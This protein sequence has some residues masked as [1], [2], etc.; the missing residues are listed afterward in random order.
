M[1]RATGSRGANG[2]SSGSVTPLPSSTPHAATAGQVGDAEGH[3]AAAA[4]ATATANQTLAGVSSPAP[5]PASSSAG[6]ANPPTSIPGPALRSGS[7]STGQTATASTP[8]AG[9]SSGA[10][11]R[12]FTNSR[13]N[14]AIAGPS[15]VSS[16]S[17]RGRGQTAASALSTHTMH[18]AAA[19]S[20]FGFE[21]AASSSRSGGNG[22]FNFSQRGT[23]TSNDTSGGR[24]SAQRIPFTS[25]GA[26]GSPRPHVGG[27][28]GAA[29]STL[30]SSIP[31]FS[32]PG[33]PGA[34]IAASNSQHGF[35][36]AGQGSWALADPA[37]WSGESSAP[38]AVKAFEE[39]TI[40]S[41]RWRISDLRLLRDEV[42]SSALSDGER[43]ISAG[44]GK[45]EI[46]T[47][48][49]IFG[50]GKWKLELVRTSRG[51]GSSG[52]KEDEEADS[53][54]EG[55]SNTVL[56]VY[57]TAM[58]LDY[59]P[60][61]ISIA[62]T[63]FVGLAPAGRSP[64][65]KTSRDGGFV[66]RHH[67]A[68]TFARDDGE[69][70]ECH[71]LPSLTEL[72]EFPAVSR[73]NAMEL[74]LQ[75]STGPRV[76]QTPESGTIRTKNTSVFED[77][78]THSVPR[79]LVNGLE[80]LLDC[81]AT[82]DVILLVKERGLRLAPDADGERHVETDPFP[83]SSGTMPSGAGAVTRD[84][85]LWA[86]SSIL[87]ARGEFWSD[88][89]A[90]S[91]AEGVEHDLAEAYGGRRVR[92]LRLPDADF[93]S[94]Y[95]LLRWLYVN[96]VEFAD[97]FNQP[98]RG[99]SFGLLD[100]SHWVTE[101][102]DTAQ[103]LPDWDW[104]ECVRDEGEEHVNGAA[105]NG[106][107]QPQFPLHTPGGLMS[108]RASHG[109]VSSSTTAAAEG[110]QHVP[111]SPPTTLPRPRRPGEYDPR[112]SRPALA[113]LNQQSPSAPTLG[114]VLSQDPHPHPVTDLAPASAL[115]IYRL[116][117]RCAQDSLAEL[118]RAHVVASLD[119]QSA[120]PTFLATGLYAELHADV[121]R[122][123]LA[124]WTAVSHSEAFERSID[125]ICAGQWGDAASR[126]LREFMRA[127]T[128]YSPPARRSR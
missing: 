60:S 45:S 89:L 47:T 82:G 9:S 20:L 124:N 24:A 49:P 91:F 12:E 90:S 1:A 115:T 15:A 73:Q 113:A 103:S 109:S 74:T 120:F 21:Q 54:A 114:S 126:S 81:S 61:H 29:G 102:E 40:T 106:Q 53:S 79:A 11:R 105:A 8:V 67:A 7:T 38:A 78:H 4:S 116:A 118:A 30:W 6:S 121:K 97:D 2:A 18:P 37:G 128:P 111:A 28:L 10:S 95:A 122:Y 51:A 13:P 35:A 93:A 17:T 98:L 112:A 99:E 57:L 5:T 104:Q 48:Q 96:E 127:L 107:Q 36:G 62:A 50:D 108:S 66:W 65:I 71:E 117:H 92:V 52:S 75:I 56:S 125:E 32:S 23:P 83:S 85:V 14:S 68:H 42:E 31:T 26:Q 41:F 87:R 34:G 44:A 39:D 16:S 84:R 43:S 69:F 3:A 123:L 59:I 86:H 33:R 63:I 88:M 72:L 101:E 25:Q 119:P 100:D 64:S 55:R 110:P 77:K 94:A 22:L 27:M 19:G 76:A 58:L 46:W 70:W 80:G